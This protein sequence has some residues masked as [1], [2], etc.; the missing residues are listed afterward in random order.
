M[1]SFT[2]NNIESGSF[3]T[4]YRFIYIFGK[5]TI[6]T[7]LGLAPWI[8]PPLLTKPHDHEGD[9]NGDAKAIVMTWYPKRGAEDKGSIEEGIAGAAIGH[10]TI[11]IMP[12]PSTLEIDPLTKAAYT[13]LWPTE[14]GMTLMNFLPPFTKLLGVGGEFKSID[15]DMLEEGGHPDSMILIQNL[16]FERM[17]KTYKDMQKNIARGHL[18]YSLFCHVPYSF[19]KLIATMVLNHYDPFSEQYIEP[20]AELHKYPVQNV[21]NCTAIVRHIL[22][23]GGF[24]VPISLFP[25]E[26]IPVVQEKEFTFFLRARPVTDEAERS[27]YIEMARQ[28]SPTPSTKKSTFK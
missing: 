25:W 6:W 18:R 12:G 26:K 14:L 23:S 7:G 2:N 1:H 21:K 17:Q 15:Y 4:N 28:V 3:T 19:D 20:D 27:N 22:Q 11:L 8:A 9:S 5:A 13:S 16:N 10:A 24:E